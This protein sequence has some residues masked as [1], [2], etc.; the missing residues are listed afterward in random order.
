[1]KY[2]TLNKT[3][4]LLLGMFLLNMVSGQELSNGKAFSAARDFL[5]KANARNMDFQKINP[6]KTIEIKTGSTISA[7]VFQLQ[8]VGY[9]VVSSYG[10]NS[11]VIGY[12]FDEDFPN[13]NELSQHPLLAVIDGINRA[14]KNE[15]NLIRNNKTDSQKGAPLFYGPY[16]STLWGQ[17]NCHD[18][19]GN[20]INVTNLYTPNNYAPG[21][22]AISM[23]TLLHYYKWPIRGEGSH[24]YT[25]SWGSSTG[26]YVANFETD[27]DWQ[28][29]RNKYRSQAS[30]MTEREAAGELVFHCDVALEMNFEYNGSTSNV[31]KIP[32]CG[33]DYFRFHSFHKQESSSIFWPRVDKNLMEANPVIFAISGSG[34]IDH[35]IVCDGLNID[36]EDYFYHLNMGWW[37]VG[38][39]WFTVREDFN[40]GGYDN[41]YG[42]VLDFIPIPMLYDAELL[43]GSDMFHLNWEFTQTISATSYDVQRK[44]NDGNWE[45][46]AEDYQDTTLLVVVDDILNDYWFRV[47]AKVNDEIYSYSWSN[48]IQLDI[49]TGIDETKTN[50]QDLINVFPNPFNNYISLDLGKAESDNSVV[51]I[52]NA[53]GELVYQLP[54]TRQKAQ[55]TVQTDEWQN[56]VYFVKISSGAG[57]TVKKIIKY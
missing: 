13:E 52:F 56:G 28:H 21:C 7:R 55:F 2:T 6:D 14:R 11:P 25:D 27:Y 8:P 57:S 35:S 36:G 22:V 46:I 40:A 17:V 49:L 48:E 29:M 42:G 9:I 23:A 45:P 19:N 51:S 34:G 3:T 16:V 5:L 39:G 33:D 32:G 1:M 12:S 44:I 31:N 24:S 50:T 26:Y 15:K 18:N 54:G 10:E 4:F 38:N 41:V 20:L 47:R 37:G 30:T 43:Y 53:M